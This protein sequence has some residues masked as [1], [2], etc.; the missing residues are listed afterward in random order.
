MAH[1]V[2]VVRAS[3]DDWAQVRDLRLAA[4][5][6]TPDA[7]G[8]TL[9]REQDQPESFWRGR[10]QAADAVTLVAWVDGR[11]AGLITVAPA[12]DD[13]DAGGIYSVWVAPFARGDH[14]T[15]AQRL[16]ARPAFGPTGRT[17]TLP[18]PREHV[19]EHEL[20]R[21]VEQ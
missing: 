17:G 18:P 7:F 20:A 2:E 21:A 8:S 19:S 13:P 3:V 12:F 5:A 11:P 4:L 1:D 14:N 10:L 9:E 6:D 15:A 16:Y